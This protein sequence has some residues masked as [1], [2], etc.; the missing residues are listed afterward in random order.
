MKA[1]IKHLEKFE[2]SKRDTRDRRKKVCFAVFSYLT[3]CGVEYRKGYTF[4][5]FTSE[6]DVWARVPCVIEVN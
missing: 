2:E 5:P 1:Y 6:V 3:L 4:E